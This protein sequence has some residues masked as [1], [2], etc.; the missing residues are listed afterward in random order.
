MPDL[1]E[2]LAILPLTPLDRVAVGI[3]GVISPGEFDLGSRDRPRRD[4]QGT[5]KRS[6]PQPRD[7]VVERIHGNLRRTVKGIWCLVAQLGL[8]C[9]KDLIECGQ[10]PL[11]VGSARGFRPLVCLLF[12]PRIVS[13][14]H[15]TGPP[16]R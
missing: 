6:E 12:G 1:D 8:E 3:D 7:N 11:H 5:W 14:W 10:E 15:R 2:V 4:L 9:R 16:D 13:G